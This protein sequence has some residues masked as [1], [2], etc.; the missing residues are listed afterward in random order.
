MA[1]GKILFKQYK[2][3]EEIGAGAFG[4]TYIA[5]D[6]AFPGEPRR[7]VKHLCPQNTNP[8]NLEI[9]KRLFKTEAECLSR[10][11]EHNQIPRL[12]SYFGEEGEFYLVQELIE[13]QDLTSEFQ[14]GKKWSEAE[15]VEFLQEL[16]SILS[17]VHQENTIHRD[18]KPANI[19]RRQSDRRLVLIDFGAVKKIL[20]GDRQGKTTLS[21]TVGIGTYSYMPPEQA[22]GRPGKYSD[23]YAVGMLGIQ[24]LSGLSSRE[25]PQDS[26]HLQQMWNDLDLEVSPQLKYVLGKMVSFQYKQRF[27]DANEA[28]KALIPTEIDRRSGQTVPETKIVKS[29]PKG[30]LLLVLFGAIGLAGVGITALPLLD[31]PNYAQL[32]TYLQN[33]QWQQADAETNKLL[34][35]VANEKSALDAESIS[36]IPCQ[37]L[38]KIDELWTNHSDG[39]FG[40]TPQKKAYLSTGN[41]FGQYTESAYEE[42]G[43]KVKWRTFGAWGLYGDLKF[44]NIAP[45]GHLPSPGTMSSERNDLRFLERGMLLS[46]FD[47]CGL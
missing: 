2:I 34:L 38:Q 13:G 29:Q 27:Q 39:N 44:T 5:L 18:I 26:E 23:V 40:F 36:K 11:G 47:S 21:S 16:L 25:L 31:R 17:V 22:M 12:Y 45:S 35:K 14:P 42:F 41:E 37:A 8:R 33:Q 9:A 19:M 20:T 15:T 24:A 10:L 7:V 43:N 3:I 1:I 6:K 28:L 30:K 46:R 4:N 32:E